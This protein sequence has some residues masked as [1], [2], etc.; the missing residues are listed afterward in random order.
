M[1]CAGTGRIKLEPDAA[2]ALLG[3]IDGGIRLLATAEKRAFRLAESMVQR[4]DVP[5]R[6]L[7]ILPT[8]DERRA[9]D[10]IEVRTAGRAELFRE[11]VKSTFVCDIESPS[12]LRRNFAFNAHIAASTPAFILRYPPG[13][14]RVPAVRDAILGHLR[15]QLQG[16]IQ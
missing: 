12:R 11:L 5:L 13:L 7:V 3:G 4:C 16:D 14:E 9:A 15:R 8:P 1:A 2:S 6:A 10:R